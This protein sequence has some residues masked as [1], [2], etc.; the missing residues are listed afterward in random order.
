[1]GKFGKILAG[2]L[3]GFFILVGLVAI[4]VAVVNAHG[5][6]S[7][8]IMDSR[9]GFYLYDSFDEKSLSEDIKY[10]GY[11]IEVLED[12]SMIAKNFQYNPE[13]NSIKYFLSYK[14][15]Y[16]N[17]YGYTYIIN[18]DMDDAFYLVFNFVENDSLIK[19]KFIL[20]NYYTYDVTFKKNI[21]LR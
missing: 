19:G 12:G 17:L 18:F 8:T 1:M 9:N 13:N 15:E 16:F 11:E 5:E 21:E 6:N 3:A 14:V 20:Y 10:T 2:A 7:L 4:F